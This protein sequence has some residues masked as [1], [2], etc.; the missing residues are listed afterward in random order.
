MQARSGNRKSVRGWGAR[1]QA[2]VQVGVQGKERGV[3]AAQAVLI[4]HHPHQVH[5]VA[6][7]SAL[8]GSMLAFYTLLPPRPPFQHAVFAYTLEPWAARCSEDLIYLSA[9]RDC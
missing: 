4:G 6:C 9:V 5:L 8:P 7:V 2:G 1:H 3:Y